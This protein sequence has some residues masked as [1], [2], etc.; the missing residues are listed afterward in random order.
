MSRVCSVCH[1]DTC[2]QHEA[3]S[4]LTGWLLRAIYLPNWKAI[5]AWALALFIG[6]FI[7]TKAI[8]VVAQ[9]A[10]DA[11]TAEEGWVQE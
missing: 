4:P 7:W 11:E 8:T 3:F 1:E 10:Y 6:A 5:G 9:L 2:T